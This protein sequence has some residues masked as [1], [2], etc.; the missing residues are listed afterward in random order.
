[1]HSST[2]VIGFYVV[3]SQL[4]DGMAKRT[5]TLIGLTLPFGNPNKRD[6]QAR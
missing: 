2:N 1:M 5:A 3:G 6:I 4:C